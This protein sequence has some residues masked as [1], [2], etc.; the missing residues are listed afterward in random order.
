MLS[1]IKSFKINVL[2]LQLAYNDG[3]LAS[4]SMKITIQS[5]HC[6]ALNLKTS[7][8]LKKQLS[9]TQFVLIVNG[10]CNIVIR[11]FW[12]HL[13][14]ICSQNSNILKIQYGGSNMVDHKFH[15][16]NKIRPIIYIQGFLRSLITNL[17]SGFGNIE[18]QNYQF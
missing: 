3:A 5:I 2:P 11:G 7:Q 17:K 12:G 18:N 10:N 8:K 14:R 13:L 6:I 1:H 16:F 9:V 15:F 4:L